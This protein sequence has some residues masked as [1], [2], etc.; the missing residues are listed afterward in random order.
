MCVEPSGLTTDQE[1]GFIEL[2]CVTI[3]CCSFVPLFCAAVLCSRNFQTRQG[4]AK[5]VLGNE[6]NLKATVGKT[7]EELSFA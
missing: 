5:H 2:E 7:S 6:W 3:F 1:T 4:R